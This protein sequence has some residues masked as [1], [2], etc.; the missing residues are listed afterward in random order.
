MLRNWLLAAAAAA[1][2]LVSMPTAL[3]QSPSESHTPLPDSAGVSPAFTPAL[4]ASVVVVGLVLIIVVAI[5]LLRRRIAR[6]YPMSQDPNS[7]PSTTQLVQ[8]PLDDPTPK[9]PPPTHF[10]MWSSGRGTDTLPLPTPPTTP[11]SQAPTYRWVDMAPFA[12]PTTPVPRH[13]RFQ[14]VQDTPSQ[15]DRLRRASFV[16]SRPRSP[17][18]SAR[19]STP[20]TPTTTISRGPGTTV[21]DDHLSYIPQAPESLPEIPMSALPR[22]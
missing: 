9:P 16:S 21:V 8:T 11:S 10:R 13:A 12:T 17:P 20:S 15:L 5:F 2:L 19:P 3:A 14:W 7:I 6:S 1:Q 4:I 22:S 18:G